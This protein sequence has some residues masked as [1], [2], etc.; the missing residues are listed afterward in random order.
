MFLVQLLVGVCLC[1]AASGCWN[2]SR[3]PSYTQ[4]SQEDM[5]YAKDL[6]P[7][8][9]RL[10]VNSESGGFSTYNAANK[11]IILPPFI[12]FKSFG[13]G[14]SQYG[15]MRMCF[16]LLYFDFN[17]SIYD[18][19]GKAQTIAEGSIYD[20]IYG[21]AKA[22]DFPG[23]VQMSSMTI[24]PIT[25]AGFAMYHQFVAKKEGKEST[26]RYEVLCL[27]IIGS[28]VATRSGPGSGM[29]RILWIPVGSDL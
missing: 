26:S 2:L 24:M 13:S 11:I 10:T 18:S 20:P 1:I 12:Y 5:Q 21:Y 6:K 17:A 22:E 16:A 29:P 27:P 8:W 3:D 7:G 15:L 4:L 25:I 9:V 19:T 23:K 28:C 14:N